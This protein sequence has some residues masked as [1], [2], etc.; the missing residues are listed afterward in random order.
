MIN[1]GKYI[2]LFRKRK[3]MI[4]DRTDYKAISGWLLGYFNCLKKEVFLKKKK[5]EM[6]MSK[7]VAIS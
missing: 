7:F 5:R 2:E 3:E 4:F 6:G 1:I